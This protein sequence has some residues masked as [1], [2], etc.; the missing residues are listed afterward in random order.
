MPN[1]LLEADNTDDPASGESPLKDIDLEQ[2]DE[3][4][5]FKIQ[6]K[7]TDKFGQEGLSGLNGRVFLAVNKVYVDVLRL[8]ALLAPASGDFRPLLRLLPKGVDGVLIFEDSFES[9]A[10]FKIDCILRKR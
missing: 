3:I 8:K 10:S 2:D 6:H 9:D 7:L 1:K 5:E 4:F